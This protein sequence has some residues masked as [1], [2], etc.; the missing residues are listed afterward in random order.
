M[1]EGCRPQDGEY[2][3]SHWRMEGCKKEEKEEK[4]ERSGEW[5]MLVMA[6]VQYR[7]QKSQRVVELD[8]QCQIY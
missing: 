3:Q 7:Q 1:R 5:L 4:E 2:S 8:L 6:V